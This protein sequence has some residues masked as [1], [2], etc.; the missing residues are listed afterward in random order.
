MRLKATGER[1][2]FSGI[3]SCSR[4]SSSSTRAMKRKPSEET[5]RIRPTSLW[6]ALVAISTQRARRLGKPSMTSSGRA[7]MAS[8]RFRSGRRP[9]P[10]RPGCRLFWL[11]D[12]GFVFLGRDDFDRGPHRRVGLT[13]EGR[14]AGRRRCLP[15]RRGRRPGCACPGRRRACP[16]GPARTRCGRRRSRRGRGR[17]R[18]RPGRRA[19]NRRRLRSGSRSATAT[20]GR[21][22]RSSAASELATW[23]PSAPVAGVSRALSVKTM[24]RTSSDRGEEREHGP[25]PELD[26]PPAAELPRLGSALAAVAAQGVEEGDVDRHDDDRGGDEADRQQGVDLFGAR[27][28]GRQSAAILYSRADAQSLAGHLRRL[29]VALRAGAAGAVAAA[30]AVPLLRKRARIPAPVTSPPA[31]PGRWRSPSCGRAP[32]GRDVALF[33][34]QM[35]AF[36]MV[37]ELPYDDPERLRARLRARYPIAVDR[38]IGLGRLPNVRLQR[39]LAGSA[40]G[41]RAQP[42]SSPGSTGSGSSSPTAPCSTSSCATPSTSRAPRA[43]SPPSS[44]PAAPSTSRCRRRRPGGPPSRA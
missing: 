17:P 34:M 15:R 40:R 33:A 39:A 7:L 12:E 37:H 8:L 44:T 22:L 2:V 20:A 19:C 3:A 28:M 29:R 26:P 24:P 31:P 11:L 35:W 30:F 42:R 32:G 25:D 1:K 9:G 38:A 4:I 6:S 14:R 16:P 36:I 18:C 27:G 41:R 21:S 23:R 5:I 13:G 10:G 43:G